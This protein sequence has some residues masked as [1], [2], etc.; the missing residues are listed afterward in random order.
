MAKYVLVVLTNAVEGREQAFNEWYDGQHVSDVLNVPGIVSAQRFMVSE[1]QRSP[2]PHR[3]M[4]FYEIETDDLAGVLETVKRRSG[5]PAMPRSDAMASD[6][7]LWI[8]E[9]IGSKKTF[10]P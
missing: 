1:M 5:T 10:K 8:Y 9:P 4:A 3:Y 6:A 2:N 7:A